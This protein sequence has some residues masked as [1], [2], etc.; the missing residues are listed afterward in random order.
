M[1]LVAPPGQLPPSAT[2]ILSATMS[3]IDLG[4]NCLSMGMGM[5]SSGCGGTY[6]KSALEAMDASNTHTT[7]TPRQRQRRHLLPRHH[8]HPITSAHLLCSRKSNDSCRNPMSL[9]LRLPPLLLIPPTPMPFWCPAQTCT[10]PL[11]RSKSVDPTASP[12]HPHP[13]STPPCP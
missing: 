5:G 3:T 11:P 13:P 10:T 9:Y 8:H 1:L 2:P 12:S 4:S 7:P 6:S